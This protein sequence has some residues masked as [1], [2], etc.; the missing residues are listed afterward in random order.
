MQ[1]Y[2]CKVR[3]HG[4]LYNEVRKDAITAAEIQ[5]LKVIH[6]MTSGVE[7]VADIEHVGEDRN[8]T[9]AQER[10]SLM[11]RYATGL[12]AIESVKDLNG[13]F[14]IGQPLPNAIPGVEHVSKSAIAAKKAVGRPRKAP[15]EPATED[16]DRA[17]DSDLDIPVIDDEDIE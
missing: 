16:L 9:D 4:S 2:D 14:G 15:A 13:I 17:D 8:R 5:V 3:L 10:E 7:S 1:L 6:G 12:A 11:N